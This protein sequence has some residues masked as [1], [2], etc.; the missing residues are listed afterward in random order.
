MASTYAHSLTRKQPGRASSRFPTTQRTSLLAKDGA[1]ADGP[2]RSK[3][4]VLIS[5]WRTSA[6]TSVLL[7]LHPPTATTRHLPR[8]NSNAIP[9]LSSE[10]HSLFR[11][12]RERPSAGAEATLQEFVAEQGL[13]HTRWSF[14]S[15]LPHTMNKPIGRIPLRLNERWVKLG[16]GEPTF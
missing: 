2:P 13:R 10:Q 14:F 7:N 1:D 15:P 6:D 12:I 9:S 5:A 11:C 8:F 3:S 4:G 16:K